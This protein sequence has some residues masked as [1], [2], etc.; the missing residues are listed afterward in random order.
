MVTNKIIFGIGFALLYGNLT[1]LLLG[2]GLIGLAGFARRR[3][4]K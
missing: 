1:L 3:F 2:S 4:K